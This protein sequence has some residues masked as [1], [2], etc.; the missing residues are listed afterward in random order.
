MHFHEDDASAGNN[1][2]EDGPVVGAHF[3]RSWWF[4]APHCGIQSA[5]DGRS[6]VC[7]DSSRFPDQVD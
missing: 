2:V 4:G 5:G 3:I 7:F 1:C 6:S